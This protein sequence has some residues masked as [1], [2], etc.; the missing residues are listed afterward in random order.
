MEM[1]QGDMGMPEEPNPY[2]NDFD[3]GVDTD[4]NEDP[5]RYI[6]QLTGKLSQKLRDYNGS[7]PQPDADLNKFVA[8]MINK[9]AVQGLS[10][11]DVKTIMDRAIEDSE[12]S[13]QST[14]EPQEPQAPNE[15]QTATEARIRRR[16]TIDELFQELT[17][18]GDEPQA[19][20]PIR[21]VEPNFKTKPFTAPKFNNK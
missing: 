1:P 18:I 8:G 4:E 14:E 2:E 11:D 17:G 21:R 3:A 10:Q 15:P 9:Q 20:R 13:Q 16:Q 19:E 7:L 12:E 5:K 6:Q